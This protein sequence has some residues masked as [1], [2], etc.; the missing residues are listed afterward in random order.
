MRTPVQKAKVCNFNDVF[1]LIYDFSHSYAI[2]C[3]RLP[4]SLGYSM[5]NVEGEAF[6]VI[7]EFVFFKPVKFGS[8]TIF[9]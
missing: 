6:D 9:K 1:L 8:A 5:T 3:I 7:G 4:L 2:V